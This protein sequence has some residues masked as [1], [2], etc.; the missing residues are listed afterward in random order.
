M[1]KAMWE[2]EEV[3]LFL[4]AQEH[5]TGRSLQLVGG[6]E[7][8]DFVV[9]RPTSSYA[10]LELTSVYRDPPH[11][12]VPRRDDWSAGQD[13]VSEI[14]AMADA[15]AKKRQAPHWRY[16][17]QTIL[18]LMLRDVPLEEVAPFLDD[19]PSDEFREYGFV[20][21]WVADMTFDHLD[22]YGGDIELYGILPKKWR[23]YHRVPGYP[24]RKPYG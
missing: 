16:R 2:R 22:R 20:E 5:V 4:D 11:E 1:G 15:K 23:G 18:V 6:G 14:W 3:G 24:G 9:K 21:V 8:P 13:A 12:Y 19:A 10:G 7:S 17:L